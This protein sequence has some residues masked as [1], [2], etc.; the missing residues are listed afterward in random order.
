MTVNSTK[1]RVIDSII[2]AEGGYVND[3]ADSGGETMY[4]ITAE[5]ARANG[6]HWAMKDLPRELAVR[7][8]ERKYWDSVRAD[9]I[10]VLST[11]VAAEVVDT[12]VNTG[13]ERAA[14]FL[15][16]ALNA[17]NCGE[18]L[19]PNIRADGKVGA[20]TIAALRAYLVARDEQTL[21]KAL[22]CLQGA[23]YIELAERREKDE[24]FLYGWL[25]T[26]ISL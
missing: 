23:Y 16:R 12:V 5:V 24:R 10:A 3:P 22:N 14:M 6:Y 21:L 4:G 25:R 20:A 26:R 8:Y 18:K 11:P 19:Y 15:Q 7:I 9:D 17:L 1:Q 2:A 13:P